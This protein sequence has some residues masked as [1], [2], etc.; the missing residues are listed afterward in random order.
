MYITIFIVAFSILVIRYAIIQYKERK[1]KRKYN[2][3]I[4]EYDEREKIHR[5][6]KR[7]KN[8]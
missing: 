3:N 6:S 8:S 2:K 7:P 1:L 4:L 5:A